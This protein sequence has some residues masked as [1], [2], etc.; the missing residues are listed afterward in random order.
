MIMMAVTVATVR[1]HLPLIKII[2]D[3]SIESPWHHIWV[4]VA[5]GASARL[6]LIMITGDKSESAYSA[7]P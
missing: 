6:N 5:A 4:P 2:S 7:E 1:D 3:S